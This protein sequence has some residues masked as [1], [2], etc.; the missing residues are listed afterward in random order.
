M[1]KE[2]KLRGPDDGDGM[3]PGWEIPLSPL[4]PGDVERIELGEG[5]TIH[6]VGTENGDV[7]VPRDDET[8]VSG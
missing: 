6:I 8:I 5:T 2:I 7:I 3:P 4:R 1:T